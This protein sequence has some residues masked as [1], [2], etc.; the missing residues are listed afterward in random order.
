MDDSE[1]AL[2]TNPAAVTRVNTG[3]MQNRSLVKEHT[4]TMDGA[5]ER[6]LLR[7]KVVKARPAEDFSGG[8]TEYVDD[9]LGCVEYI[10]IRS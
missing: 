1:A 3:I 5:G 10:G 6:H 2:A 8:V 9:G 7:V 4:A